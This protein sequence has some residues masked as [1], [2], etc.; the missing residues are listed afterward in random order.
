MKISNEMVKA[1]NVQANME[2]AS[3][4]IYLSMSYDMENAGFPGFAH[5]L[6]VQYEEE[7]GHAFKLL[8]YIGE[9]GAKVELA[10]IAGYDQHFTC[11]LETA[12]AVL[13]HEQLVTA[14][15]EKI[16]GQAREEK[17]YAAELFLQWFITEQVEE[18]VNGRAL[19]EKFSAAG[20]TPAALHHVDRAL[21][22]RQ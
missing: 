9:R 22:A 14:A 4:Y 3:A 21:N 8:S 13:A 16:F 11:P 17:D 7:R 1:L 18:E 20:T 5:W 12:K 19:I 10:P 15:L 2:F 6:K